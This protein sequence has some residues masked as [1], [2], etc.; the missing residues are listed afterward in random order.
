MSDISSFYVEYP[1]LVAIIIAVVVP[2][3]VLFI[4]Y[5]PYIRDTKKKVKRH[6][7]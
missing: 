2:I 5:H 3:V 1:K 7:M 4:T 6:A